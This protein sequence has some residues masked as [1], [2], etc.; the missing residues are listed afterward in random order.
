MGK[1]LGDNRVVG[2]GVFHFSGPAKVDDFWS[3]VEEEKKQS[4]EQLERF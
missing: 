3:V 1:A 2:F 4:N